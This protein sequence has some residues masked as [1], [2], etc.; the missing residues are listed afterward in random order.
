[1]QNLT[2]PKKLAE[3]FSSLPEVEAVAL[4]GS[5]VTGLSDSSSDIDLYVFTR[6]DIPLSSRQAIVDKNGG[7]LG[8]WSFL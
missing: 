2:I 6:T 3:L 7:S 5:H 1:M 8:F 4:G